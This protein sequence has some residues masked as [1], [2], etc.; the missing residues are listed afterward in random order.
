ML[1]IRQIMVPEV[2][3]RWLSRGHWELT[4]IHGI[5]NDVIAISLKYIE[6]LKSPEASSNSFGFLCFLNFVM[7]VLDKII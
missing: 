5:N 1:R 4:I 6:T 7:M 2:I 3:A